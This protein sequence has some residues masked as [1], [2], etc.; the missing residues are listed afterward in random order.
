MCTILGV[1][2]ET[3]YWLGSNSDNPWDTRTKICV[4]DE[5]KYKFIG[6]KLKCPNDDLPW[7]NMMTRGVN[8]AGIAFTF[9]FVQRDLSIPLKDGIGFK[10]FGKTILGQFSSLSEIEYF[11][12]NQD[13]N[14]SGNFIFADDKGS[15]LFGEILPYE[16]KLTWKS[17]ETVLRTNHFLELQTPNSQELHPSSTQRYQSMVTA[18]KKHTQSDNTSIYL[19]HLLQN[20]ESAELDQEFG[21]SN[22]SHGQNSGTISSEIIDPENR[23]IW[24]CYGSPCHD[25][26][27]VQSWDTYIPFKLSDYSSGDITDFEG[28]I[29]K[30]IL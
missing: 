20:H 8:E 13:V 6:T 5:Y 1:Y 21:S 27:K 2:A 18:M 17:S 4:N 10:E 23:T 15:L 19:R 11:L 29:V 22:C 25:T 3:H 14:I 30:Q 12:K 7:A 16:S 9:A 28:E 24:Y 26:E